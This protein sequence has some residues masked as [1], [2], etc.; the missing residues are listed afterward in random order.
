MKKITLLLTAF[1]ISAVAISQ[2]V[3]IDRAPGDVSVIA[4]DGTDGNQV[5]IGDTFTLASDTT[6]G[7]L[8]LFGV[9]SNEGELGALLHGFTVFIYADDASLPAG[10]PTVLGD[11]VVELNVPMTAVT[12]LEDAAGVGNFTIALTA[13]NGGTQITL[14]A[15][16]YWLV[17]GANT[18]DSLAAGRWNWQ[19]STVV[20]DVE[21]VLIDPADLFGAAITVWTNINDLITD[22]ATSMAWQ[23]R[24]EVATVAVGDNVLENF[25]I[26]PNP[27][28]DVLNVK[29]LSSIEVLSATLFDILGKD[30]GVRLSNGTMNTSNIAKGVYFLN[31]KTDAGS[32]TQKITK[33]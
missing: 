24:D 11:G 22:P 9:N 32:F 17:I 8:D 5:F 12:V 33:M 28:T 25:S 27:A 15:G 19:V 26:F 6:L 30:T 29:T 7:E 21:P 16:D 2:T 10:D 13:A 4:I 14:P 23:L 3:V 18:D 31:V 1:L 20:A